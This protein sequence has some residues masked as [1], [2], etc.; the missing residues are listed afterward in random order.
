MRVDLPQQFA[1][2]HAQPWVGAFQTEQAREKVQ[3][4]MC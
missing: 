3:A 1:F 2:E 4:W